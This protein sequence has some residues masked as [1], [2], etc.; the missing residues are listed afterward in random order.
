MM[1]IEEEEGRDYLNP[2][3]SPLAYNCAQFLVFLNDLV[4]ITLIIK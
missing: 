4:L 3:P 1:K 2:C